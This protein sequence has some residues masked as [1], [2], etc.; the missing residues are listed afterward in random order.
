M[1]QENAKPWSCHDCGKQQDAITNNGQTYYNSNGWY[2]V[3]LRP[4][5]KPVYLD[6]GCYDS[7]DQDW[8]DYVGTHESSPWQGGSW[9]GKWLW[10]LPADYF[11]RRDTYRKLPRWEA[12]GEGYRLVTHDHRVLGGIQ[13]YTGD[14]RK[15][16]QY[17]LV[18]ADWRTLPGSEP[19]EWVPA[20]RA[21]EAHAGL[22]GEGA[23]QR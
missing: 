8:P 1:N 14:V 2:W 9:E 12:H 23:V 18:G 16:G 15:K 20:K 13:R 21:I 10:A 4:D 3:Q 6:K 5:E 7:Y 17:R 22:G 19:M 11:E